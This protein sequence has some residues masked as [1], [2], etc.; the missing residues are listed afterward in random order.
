MLANALYIA[1]VGTFI[2]IALVGHV[3]LLTAIVPSRR[4][5][6]AKR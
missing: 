5:A 2:G 3:L 1:F 6:S 4:T